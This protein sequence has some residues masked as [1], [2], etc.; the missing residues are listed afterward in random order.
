MG[1]HE[2]T[3]AQ[4]VRLRHGNDTFNFNC[5]IISLCKAQGAPCLPENA[6]T[7]ITRSAPRL[8][9]LRSDTSRTSAVG[10]LCQFGARWR[11]ATCIA[12]LRASCHDGVKKT[13]DG[14]GG[15]CSTSGK[16]HFALTG[17]APGGRKW[18]AVAAEY[19]KHFASALASVLISSAEARRDV[20]LGQLISG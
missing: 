11:K 10:H 13:C 16:Y 20:A 8:A 14:R 17:A 18:T 7:S 12:G 15:V 1:L 2:L 5:R 3:S 4:R 19:P 6:Q 9:C